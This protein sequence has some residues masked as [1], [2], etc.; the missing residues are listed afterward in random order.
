MAYEY[1]PVTHEKYWEITL[2]V[3]VLRL[4]R[5]LRRDPHEPDF[6]AWTKRAARAHAPTV[7]RRLEGAVSIL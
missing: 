5:Q 4:D 7:L 3:G 2:V 6:F 1:G